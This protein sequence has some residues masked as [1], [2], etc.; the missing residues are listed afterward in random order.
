M[1]MF[2]TV[3]FSQSYFWVSTGAVQMFTDICCVF[4]RKAPL[5]GP[6]NEKI[7]QANSM[8][9]EWSHKAEGGSG[10]LDSLGFQSEE[11]H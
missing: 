4:S 10:A 11:V 2:S 5:Q 3:M 7:G 9:Y 1:Q 6:A 8:I